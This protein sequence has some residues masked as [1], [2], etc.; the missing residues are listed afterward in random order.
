MCKRNIEEKYKW[1]RQRERGVD[2]SI[3]IE[4]IERKRERDTIKVFRE[5]WRR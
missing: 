1:A 4:K 5:R 3:K 2:T